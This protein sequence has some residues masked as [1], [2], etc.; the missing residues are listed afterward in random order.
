MI[1][2]IYE[3]IIYDALKG[4]LS[5][6]QINKFCNTYILFIK[7]KTNRHFPRMSNQPHSKWYV[8]DYSESSKFGQIINAII[9]DKLD[10]LHANLKTIAKSI[11][12]I[13]G[14]NVDT[15]K[16]IANNRQYI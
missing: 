2:G 15:Y 9:N 3:H 12:Q 8:K 4:T 6:N 16:K 5:I 13:N 11:L 10:D 1:K 7:N 14:I